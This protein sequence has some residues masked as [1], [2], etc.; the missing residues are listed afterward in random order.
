MRVSSRR[1]VASGLAKAA[2]AAAA[3][4][5]LAVAAV[6][7]WAWLAPF[8]PPEGR[9][10]VPGSVYLAADG[11]V[12]LRESADGLRIPVPL[13]R[14][15]PAMVDATIAAED[16][17]F[18]SHPGVDPI[19]IARAAATF[20]SNPSGASTITQQLARA[21]YLDD[22]SPRLVRKA[23]ESLLALQLERHRTKDEILALYLNSVYYGR[24][25]YGVEAAARV[26]FG[27]SAQN[28]DVAQAAFLAGLPQLPSAYE[29]S[30]DTA[31]AKSR[32]A[33]VLD[34][35]RT[36]GRL[37][38][39]SA[40]NAAA[41]ELVLVPELAPPLA[42]HFVQFA[43]EELAALQPSMSDR[44]GLVIETTIDPALQSEVERSIQ[45]Q[46]SALKEKNAGN[47]AVV[48]LD[49]HTGALLAM[50]GSANFDDPSIDGQVNVALQPRQPGSALKPFLYAAA[51]ERGYTA[52]STLLDVP[53]TFATAGGAYS[54]MN[55]D[56]QF[57]GVVTLRTAL[58]SSYNVPAVRALDALGMDAFLEVAHRFGLRTLSNTEVYGPAVVLGG[59]EVRLLDLTAAYGALA[60]GGTLV[61][62]FAVARVR[63]AA[64]RTI[65]ERPA[66][67]TTRVLDEANAWLLADILSDPNA[68]IPGFGEV[69]PLDLP[70]RAAA[71]TGTTTGFRDNW[72]AGFTADRAVGVWVGNTDG[73]PMTDVSG[74]DGAG[75]IWRDVMFATA[76]RTPP[77]WLTQPP[78][79]VRLTVCAPTGQLPGEHCPT[80]QAEWFRAG[81]EPR[82]AERYYVR[83]A[84][85]GL[86][87]APPAEAVGWAR[88]AGL[89]IAAPEASPAAVRVLQPSPGAVL[90][91]APELGTQHALL[92]AAAAESATIELRVDGVTVGRETGSSISVQ[93][94]LVAGVHTVEAVIESNGVLS[95]ATSTFE[96]RAR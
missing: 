95:R 76:E 45:R 86:A 13:D 47:A 57:H 10:G 72:T 4:P 46:L 14:I 78:G 83:A 58:A 62:P 5:P 15:A 93:W 54:P 33:Y 94:P 11:S 63:D 30:P 89:R 65:Y 81:T 43:R 50:A 42:R 35:M 16:Q 3:L 73:S 36:T 37:D 6:I 80:P 79:L 41:E 88:S 48:V 27:T 87:I 49:P 90:Y 38:G 52:A 92:R 74:V 9:L 40:A 55:Y 17:R 22:A 85:G 1:S 51:L 44:S 39:S 61:P 82:T 2:L 84:D 28:L 77:R 7:A 68:R 34:R 18:A 66:A 8:A 71:K 75:P 12:L 67:V 26:Y 53:S 96:V 21:A 23:H 32:Q 60:T 56:R 64:G 24:A 29:P 91:L 70:F 25:A 59:G 19:A 69:T 20:R 31:A